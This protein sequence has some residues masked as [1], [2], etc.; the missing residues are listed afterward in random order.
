MEGYREGVAWT[1][2]AYDIIHRKR[3]VNTATNI[4]V[5]QKTRYYQSSWTTISFSRSI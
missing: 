4:P 1:E 2:L 5:A 3:L